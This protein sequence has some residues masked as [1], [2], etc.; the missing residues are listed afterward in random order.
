MIVGHLLNSQMLFVCFSNQTF[1]EVESHSTHVT[2]IT[3]I[4]NRFLFALVTQST[5][6]S[7]VQIFGANCYLALG[8][9]L[10]VP[11]VGVVT[12]PMW[13][14]AN[15]MV[16]NPDNPAYIPHAFSGISGKMNFW[17]RLKNTWTLLRSKWQ[18]NHYGAYQDEKIKKYFGPDAP[19]LSDLERNLSLILTNSHYSLHGVRPFTTA[20]VEVGGLHVK[21]DA[22]P[23]PYVSYQWRK[24]SSFLIEK[25]VIMFNIFH[26]TFRS[27]WT[28]VKTVS[29]SYHS[30][31]C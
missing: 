19:S 24:Y 8:N 21:E 26:R 5:I 30:V 25:S 4:W 16:A 20:V 18:F 3:L 22:T 15:D 23:L 1:Q 2:Y 31:P 7:S 9:H 17:Q 13:P 10:N 12:S 29:S 14:W 11:M 27:G 28:I 6:L